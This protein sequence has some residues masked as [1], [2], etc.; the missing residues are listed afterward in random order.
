LLTKVDQQEFQSF[1]TA[2]NDNKRLRYEA[3][4]SSFSDGRNSDLPVLASSNPNTQNLYDAQGLQLQVLPEQRG[5]G[6]I[7]NHLNLPRLSELDVIPAAGAGPQQASDSSREW[8][9]PYEPVPANS[10][11]NVEILAPQSGIISPERSSFGN[12]N[13]LLNSSSHAP[14]SAIVSLERSSFSN[15]N[16]LLNST[17]G[18]SSRNEKGPTD[19]F[20]KQQPNFLQGT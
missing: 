4:V 15:I 7:Q 19:D 5:F 9:S 20:Q 18:C 16:S 3:N 8:V 17:E 10:R 6:T 13:S 1:P 12:I 2:S 11:P 14:Q